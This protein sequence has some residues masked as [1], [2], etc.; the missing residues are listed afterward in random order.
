MENEK[1]LTTAESCKL[2]S[3]I[4]SGKPSV[5]QYLVLLSVYSYLRGVFCSASLKGKALN[6]LQ[7][8]GVGG[9]T[10]VNVFPPAR[11]IQ[12]QLAEDGEV[13]FPQYKVK[14]LL[15]IAPFGESAHCHS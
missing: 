12:I 2:A 7:C 9:Q 4:L 11:A 10:G 13:F 15:T 5:L 14:A 1:Q 6:Y 8:L 3:V